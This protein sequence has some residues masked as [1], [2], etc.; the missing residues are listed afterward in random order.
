MRNKS[1]LGKAVDIMSGINT[2]V[3]HGLNGEPLVNAITDKINNNNLE[4]ITRS[5]TVPNF[6]VDLPTRTIDSSYVE[7]NFS[8]TDNERLDFQIDSTLQ[9][10]NSQRTTVTN[11]FNN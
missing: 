3:G 1:G 4:I 9:N 5:I 11:Y 2:G 7:R 10:S 6:S 8:G